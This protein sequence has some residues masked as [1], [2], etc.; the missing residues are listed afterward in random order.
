MASIRKRGKSFQVQ[1]R[2]HGVTDSASFPSAT[3]AKAWSAKREAEIVAGARGLIVTG[4]TVDEAL[5]RF[6]SDVCPTRKGGRWEALRLELLRRQWEC[7]GKAVDRVSSDDIG[8]LRDF[9]L[10]AVKPPSVRRELVLLAAVFEVAK[11]EWK[12]CAANPVHGVTKPAHGKA[13]K[14]LVQPAE[15]K[16]ILRAAKYRPGQTPITKTQWTAAAWCLA[17]RTGMRAGELMKLEW[18]HVDLKSRVAELIDTKNGTDRQIPLFPRALRILSAIQG[19]DP[20]ANRDQRVFAMLTNGTLDALYR[21]TRKAAGIVGLTFHDSRHTATTIL[22][23]RLPVLELAR[24]IGHHDLNSLLIYFNESAS[25][26]A[27]RASSL[28]SSAR[29]R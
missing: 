2:L 29:S 1:I 8:R 22:A 13:R 19:A 20:A 17:L 21:K 14:R 3:M 6:I 26:I 24:T 11:S 10:K 9:R 23:R 4:R 7:V 5:Q 27:S 16:A 12:W 15:Y 28:S 25:S 18:R